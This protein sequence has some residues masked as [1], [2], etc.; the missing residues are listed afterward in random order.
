MTY[1]HIYEIAFACWCLTAG[2]AGFVAGK[3]L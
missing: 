2:L 1:Q 3:H